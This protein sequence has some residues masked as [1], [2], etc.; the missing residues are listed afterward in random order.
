[1]R[2]PADTPIA[3]TGAN[4]LREMLKAK[5]LQH[6]IT[7]INSLHD[8]SNLNIRMRAIEPLSAQD[9]YY[10]MVMGRTI[11]TLPVTSTVSTACCKNGRTPRAIHCC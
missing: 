8:I 5:A 4:G 11:S 3:M 1:M 6:F 7:P 2:N 10:M 9:I